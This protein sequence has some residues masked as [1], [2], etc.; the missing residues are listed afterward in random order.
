ML[1]YL[2]WASSELPGLGLR[3]PGFEGLGSHLIGLACLVGSFGALGYW[4]LA[5]RVGEQ[6][7]SSSSPQPCTEDGDDAGG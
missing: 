6:P 1:L 4:R 7:A 3:L 5:R 2:G